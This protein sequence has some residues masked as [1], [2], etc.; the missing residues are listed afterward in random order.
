MEVTKHGIRLN[1]ETELIKQIYIYSISNEQT[2]FYQTLFKS[3]GS[4]ELV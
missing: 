3:N 1:V 2:I 4:Q